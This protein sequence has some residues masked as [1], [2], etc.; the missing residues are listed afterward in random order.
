M[1]DLAGSGGYWIATHATKIVAHPGTITGAI[2][3]IAGK[4]VTKDLWNKL[5]INWNAIQHGDNASMWS[6]VQDY[7]PYG[8]TRL[9]AWLDDIYATFI[10]RVADGRKLSVAQVKELAKGRVWTGEQALKLGLV[11]ML[12]DLKD[13]IELAKAEVGLEEQVVPIQIF[14]KSLTFTEK[15]FLMIEDDDFD[16]SYSQ[17]ISISPIIQSVTA[18]LKQLKNSLNASFATIN[19]LADIK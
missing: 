3:V 6:N 7:S 16:N 9:N 14:P 12:G 1:S 19:H 11:D 18:I 13:A 2:G 8:L 5:G 15:L 17:S 4:I 10:N